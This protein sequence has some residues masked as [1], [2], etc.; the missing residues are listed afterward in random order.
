MLQYDESMKNNKKLLTPRAILQ[1]FVIV[2][3]MPL[4]PVLISRR[5]DWW[6]GWLYVFISVAGF[7]IS[8]V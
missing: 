8:R 2:V 3:L 5:W 4:L 1:V 7:I 6:E